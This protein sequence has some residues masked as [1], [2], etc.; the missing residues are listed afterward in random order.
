MANIANLLLSS[1]TLYVAIISSIFF[2]KLLEHKDE[3]EEFAFN[4]ALKNSIL[5]DVLALLGYSL[6]MVTIGNKDVSIHI[7]FL[8][9]EVLATLTLIFNFLELKGFSLSMKITNEK[10]GKAL[11]TLSTT[12]SFLSS[13]SL[14]FKFGCL[15][16][17]FGIIR[18]DELILYVNVI[19]LGIII[20]LFPNIRKKL[21]REEYKNH[22]RKIN[23]KFNIFIIVYVLYMIGLIG[24]V[25][26]RVTK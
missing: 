11:L 6:Y 9:I 24:Y 10:L 21:T 4:N 7:I 2:I 25:I 22:Q 18:Y 26:Y 23:K 19:M 1:H 8:G 14:I 3:L 17:N 13:I 16:N 20:P 15:N 12:I 5:I